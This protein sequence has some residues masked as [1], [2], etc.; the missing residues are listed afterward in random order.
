MAIEKETLQWSYPSGYIDSKGKNIHGGMVWVG[1]PAATSADRSDLYAWLSEQ[2]GEDYS[3][4]NVMVDELS[5]CGKKDK[6]YT[7]VGK[8]AKA[9]ADAAGDNTVVLG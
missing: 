4:D 2:Y 6:A 3:A 9:A 1:K 8:E 7:T 5:T